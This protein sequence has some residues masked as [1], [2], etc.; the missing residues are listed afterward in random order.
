MLNSPDCPSLS[1][2][3]VILSLSRDLDVL[4]MLTI[5]KISYALVEVIECEVLLFYYTVVQQ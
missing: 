5:V 4:L 3:P 1:L 2:S